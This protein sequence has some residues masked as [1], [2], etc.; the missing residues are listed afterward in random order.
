[1]R[2]S[3]D[4]TTGRVLAVIDKR[5]V[6]DLAIH[7]PAS[8]F[9]V[10]IS[11]NLETEMPLATSE[12]LPP[13]SP[14]HLANGW[15]VGE[16]EPSDFARVKNRLAYTFDGLLRIDLT[17]VHQEA[18]GGGHAGVRHEMELEVVHVQAHLGD[19]SSLPARFVY[20]ILDIAR[21]AP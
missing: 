12:A 11:V 10:R 20:N 5:R 17:Q 18:D 14:T 2:V 6:A 4:A 7:V 9:D 16:G 1:M 13:S 8:P 3:R 15:V 21:R 19:S